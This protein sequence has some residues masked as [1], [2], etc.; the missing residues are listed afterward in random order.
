VPRRL[1]RSQPFRANSFG[2]FARV[3]FLGFRLRTEM[4]QRTVSA[5][6]LQ[7]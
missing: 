5:N 6:A 4:V 2:F 3:T 7:S 1:G